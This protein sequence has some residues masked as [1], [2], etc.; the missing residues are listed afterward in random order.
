MRLLRA[1]LLVIV[2]GA[3]GCAGAPARLELSPGAR[4]GILN[5]LEAEVIH[6][7]V[8]V[9][10]FDGFTNSIDVD[11]DIP[12]FISRNIE[13]ELR[14]R[15]GYTIV[16][17]AGG[18][19]SDPQQRMSRAILRTS[20]WRMAGE[21]RAFLEAAA[22]EQQL[23]AVITVSSFSSNARPQESCFAIGKEDVNTR[24]YGLFTWQRVLSR[25]S[26]RMPFGQNIASPFANIIVAVFQAKPASL[27]GAGEAPCSNVTL[28]G[29]PLEGDL[30][31]LSPEVMRELRAQ[32]ELL[33]A[34]AAR[35]GLRRAG[36][37]P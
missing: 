28:Q 16:P 3:L 4:I 12:G 36:L 11:W 13:A 33:A 29:F 26:E 34:E 6:I 18:A 15:G 2:A 21:L 27:A 17:L 25:V 31:Q 14:S 9:L 1:A 37:V 10:R 35:L 20:N 24:G 23:D 32:I 19:D 22:V 30:R 7:H 5:L 8:G